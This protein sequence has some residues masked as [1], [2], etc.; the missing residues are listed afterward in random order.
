MKW[1]RTHLGLYT[2]SVDD[3]TPREYRAL[4]PVDVQRRRKHT[5]NNVKHQVHPHPTGSHIYTIKNIS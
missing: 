3:I 5:K 1:E 4:L 2:L